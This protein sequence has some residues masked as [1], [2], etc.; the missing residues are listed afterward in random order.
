M[1]ASGHVQASPLVDAS[2]RGKAWQREAGQGPGAG[3]GAVVRT[4][5]IAAAAPPCLRLLPKSLPLQMSRVPS[6]GSLAGAAWATAACTRLGG[7][8]GVSVWKIGCPI[9]ELE[10][11]GTARSIP[12]LTSGRS[13]G[14]RTSGGEQVR[15]LLPWKFYFL[16]KA[17]HRTWVRTLS[18]HQCFIPHLHPPALGVQPSNPPMTPAPV[19]SKSL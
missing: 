13:Q 9:A 7:S 16:R 2:A 17:D 8:A 11:C 10:S 15:I 5:Y 12:L 19:D 1:K 18:A 4:K 14:A 3:R 6:A